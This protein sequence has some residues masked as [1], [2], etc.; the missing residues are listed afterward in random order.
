MDTRYKTHAS[1]R[2]KKDKDSKNLLH[3]SQ[4]GGT[5]RVK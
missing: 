5:L 1:E 2:N 3:I 4:G